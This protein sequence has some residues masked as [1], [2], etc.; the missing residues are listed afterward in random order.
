MTRLL[1]TSFMNR[2]KNIYSLLC[3]DAGAST[4][5]VMKSTFWLAVTTLVYLGTLAA[6]RYNPQW[7]PG[8][9]LSV[10]LTPLLTGVFYL[11]NLF[12]SFRL[13][14]E[15]ERRIQL[16]A[17]IFALAGTVVLSTGLNVLNANGVSIAGYPHGLEIG[18]IYLSIFLLWSVGVTI[19]TRRYK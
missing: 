15:L 5:P 11:W 1:Y 4:K 2:E 16:E 17:W 9:R 10:T 7:G 12:R 19:S 14:D 8:W 6:L 13:M 18:G 3:S